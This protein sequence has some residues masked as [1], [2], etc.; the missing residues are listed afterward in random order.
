MSMSEPT[1]QEMFRAI[2]ALGPFVRRWNLPL[3]P[4]DMDEI[5]YAVLRHAHTD[6]DVQTIQALVEQQI[7]EHE[8]KAQQLYAA[9]Q[10]NLERQR[11]P[12]NE[13]D[14]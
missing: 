14:G 7:N 10:A 12:K 6:Q 1:R 2:A 13:H 3:N 9:M 5:A 11:Q 8:A 4:E